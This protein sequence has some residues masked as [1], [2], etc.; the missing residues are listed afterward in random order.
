MRR[1]MMFFVLLTVMFV[2]NLLAA[3]PIS[4]QVTQSKTSTKVKNRWG[5]N[6]NVQAQQLR[7][8]LRNLSRDPEEI[9]LQWLFIARSQ[10]DKKLWTYSYDGLT[11]LLN[12]GQSTNVI[13]TSEK[14]VA[15]SY[16]MYFGAHSSPAGYV[17]VAFR[18]KDI[19]KCVASTQPLQVKCSKWEGFEE[20]LNA[21]PPEQ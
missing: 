9:T 5:D 10:Q 13:A 15:K 2:N 12:S 19:F 3:P 17:V 16:D 11:V 14:L 8:N 1:G 6:D 20:M 4:L 18:G 21:T 7:V